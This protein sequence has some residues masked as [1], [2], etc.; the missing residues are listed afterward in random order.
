MERAY[1]YIRVST[2]NQVKQGY[3]LDEQQEEIIKYCKDNGFE[4]IKVFRDAGISGAKAN[5]DEMCIDRDGLVD[6]LAGLKNN[7]IR[8]I[9]V[10]STSRLWRSNLVMALIHRELKK[11]NV[12][13][14]AIDRPTYSIYSNNPNDILI[15][16]MLQLLDEYERLE[17][18]LKLRRGRTQKAKGGGYAGGGA[19]YGYRAKRGSKQ[20]EIEP[21]EAQAVCRIFELNSMCPWLTLAE[22]AQTLNIEGYRGRKGYIN[23][24]LVKRVLEK[25]DFYKGIYRYSGIESDGKY[26]PII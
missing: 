3:S 10:L 2:E 14:K 1:G 25:E 26:E 16:G 20:I 12:D 8:Y 24:M 11:H 15:N 6:M 19:P 23:V 4:L 22:I 17:I 7:D 9:V 5:E 21:R 18:A 13:I